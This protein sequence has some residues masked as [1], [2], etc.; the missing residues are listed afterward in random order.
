V[1]RDLLSR[2]AALAPPPKLAEQVC[3]AILEAIGR[4][5]APDAVA[6]AGQAPGS[7]PTEAA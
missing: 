1:V 2:A 5:A 4:A 7:R 6:E 3:R